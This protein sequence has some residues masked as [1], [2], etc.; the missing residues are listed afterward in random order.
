MRIEE[1]AT[2]PID[3]PVNVPKNEAAPL[4]RLF[5]HASIAART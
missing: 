1:R 2:K 4:E 5:I 3:D